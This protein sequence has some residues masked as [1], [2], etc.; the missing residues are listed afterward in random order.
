MK[1][2]IEEAKKI[3]AQVIEISWEMT[4]SSYEDSKEIALKSLAEKG[5]AE[6][7][8]PEYFL[9]EAFMSGESAA[10]EV[11]HGMDVIDALPLNFTLYA[12]YLLSA[13][14]RSKLK[15][16]AKLATEV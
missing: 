11:N 8:I 3:L 6:A 10:I 15:S 14:E 13:I 2:S 5:L 16:E 1:E 7:W 9:H 12:T 4:E